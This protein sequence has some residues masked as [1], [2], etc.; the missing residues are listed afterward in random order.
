MRQNLS[1]IT[2]LTVFVFLSSIG[3]G[4]AQ[5]EYST[6]EASPEVTRGERGELIFLE[7]LVIEGRLDEPIGLIINRANPEFE[8]IT[9]ERSF[10]DDILRPIDK[11]EFEKRV[12]MKKYMG[13]VARPIL[14][15]S[16]TTCITTGAAS[17]YMFTQ[18][19]KGS[20]TALAISAGISG[21]ITGILLLIY[22]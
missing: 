5:I 3:L 18:K 10:M 1:R 19:E 2:F 15:I 7:G 12:K 6:T 8:M 17:I 14:W 22:M 20:A 11:E 4:F 16:S 13:P 21:A 9:F